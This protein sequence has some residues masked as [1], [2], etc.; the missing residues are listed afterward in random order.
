ML[1]RQQV[2]ALL[3]N[4]FPGATLAQIAAAA[5]A[6]MAMA[7]S[8]KAVTAASLNGPDVGLAV[9]NRFDLPGCDTEPY[10][11]N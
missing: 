4:R 10:G 11:S 3:A 9:P 6:L 8:S 2:E 1:D 7:G 5:N